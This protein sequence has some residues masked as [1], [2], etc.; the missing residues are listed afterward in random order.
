ME[1]KLDSVWLFLDVA[2]VGAGVNGAGAGGRAGMKLEL[3]RA[4]QAGERA[5]GAFEGWQIGGG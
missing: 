3:G 1:L 4:A 5:W 2:T